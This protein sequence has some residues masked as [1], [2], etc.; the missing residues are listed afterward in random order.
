MDFTLKHNNQQR[1][2]LSTIDMQKYFRE[3]RTKILIACLISLLLMLSLLLS[4]TKT[5]SKSEILPPENLPVDTFIP[6]GYV[7]IPLDIKNYKNLDSILGSTAIVD[8]YTSKQDKSQAKLIAR[9]VRLLRAPKN[10]KQL[11]ILVPS[12]KAGLFFNSS[13]SYW[14]SIQKP[15]RLGTEFVNT[16]PKPRII[17][18]DGGSSD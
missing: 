17:F 3:N 11:S 8:L 6:K 4:D 18:E 2:N 15:D 16:K 10:P 1:R 14:A 13:Q 7:L 9:R 5:K 12:S